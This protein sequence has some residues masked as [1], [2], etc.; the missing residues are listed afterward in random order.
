MQWKRLN[1]VI[2]PGVFLHGISKTQAQKNS[3]SRKFFKTQ[4]LF[5]TKT[6]GW[7]HI[8]IVT[9]TSSGKILVQNSTIFFK[10]SI[11]RHFKAQS[12]PHKCTKK[13]PGLKSV[14]RYRYQL[15]MFNLHLPPLSVSLGYTIKPIRAAV[16]LP[17]K[18]WT[19][20]N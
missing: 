11:F 18:G 2:T 15:Q 12:M 14:K 7:R 16:T 13:S 6:Q 20:S 3:K 17:Q 9:M 19:F 4:G 1:Y 8:F 5:S 10:N